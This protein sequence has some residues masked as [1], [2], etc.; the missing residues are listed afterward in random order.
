MMA[1]AW[2]SFGWKLPSSK[3]ARK[4][5][6][7]KPFAYKIHLFDKETYADELRRRKESKMR[8]VV[9]APGW[10]REAKQ[11]I[12]MRFT[13]QIGR[14]KQQ[15]KRPWYCYYMVYEY[16]AP[17]EREFLCPYTSMRA[18]RIK[19]N[20][21][22]FYRNY[23]A[24]C[25]QASQMILDWL[26]E[27]DD[28]EYTFEL[29]QYLLRFVVVNRPSRHWVERYERQSAAQVSRAIRGEWALLLQQESD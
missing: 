4:Y 2:R 23:Y 29:H 5:T 11:R 14:L 28:C 20:Y 24:K 25:I 17:S 16:G 12:Q 19:E 27:L 10:K 18:R 7:N 15:I 9:E 6:N 22:L 13:H 1:L 3:V 21:A 26:H 8:M